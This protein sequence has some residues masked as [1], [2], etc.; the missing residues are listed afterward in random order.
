MR[1]NPLKSGQCFLRLEKAKIEARKK[2]Y[3][4]RNPLKSGQCFL[5][6]FTVLRIKE[7]EAKSQS[8]QIGSMFLTRN[9]SRK[10]T[11]NTEQCRN[12]L[13]SGQCFLLLIFYPQKI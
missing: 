9:K 7:P 1:R 12:P 6:T 10:T 11:E 3:S 2:G 4:G 5:Q 8:P 13:K